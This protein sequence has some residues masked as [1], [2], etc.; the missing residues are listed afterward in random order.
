MN[1]DTHSPQLK[2]F[3]HDINQSGG[4]NAS[5]AVENEVLV[6]AGLQMRT[7][8]SLCLSVLA[9]AIEYYKP[10]DLIWLNVHDVSFF[11][12]VVT[13]ADSW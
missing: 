11:Y 8:Y 13:I 9:G 4:K 10:G 6:E 7:R 1:V 2:R 12:L 5:L 3:T